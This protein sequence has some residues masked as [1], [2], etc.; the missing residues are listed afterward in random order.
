MIAVMSKK[1]TKPTAEK[2][3]KVLAMRMPPELEAALQSFISAQQFPPDRTAVGLRA[4]ENFLREQG[5]YPPRTRS[6]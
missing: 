2:R 5:H 6:G 4:L 1:K 3:E